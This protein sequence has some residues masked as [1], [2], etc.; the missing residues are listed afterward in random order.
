VLFG[1][2]VL[3]GLSG[4]VYALMQLRRGG[5]AAGADKV[6]QDEEK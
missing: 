4:Y 3:S 5:R 1:A 2:F 6:L